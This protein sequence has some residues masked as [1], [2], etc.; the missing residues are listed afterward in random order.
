MP[1]HHSPNND[2]NTSE[3]VRG[4]KVG[5]SDGYADCKKE[6]APKDKPDVCKTEIE[7]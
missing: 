5:Y 4:Y 2:T 1:N 3:Y 7:F 6:Q